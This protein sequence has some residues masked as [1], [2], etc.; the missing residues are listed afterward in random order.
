MKAKTERVFNL[1][2]DRRISTGPAVSSFVVYALDVGHL[3]LAPSSIP[4]YEKTALFRDK[5]QATLK[6]GQYL[7]ELPQRVY[8][9]YR[10]DEADYTVM[11]SEQKPHTVEIMV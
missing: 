2:F 6:N 11:A 10:L 4:E 7:V 5:A 1:K 3:A 8:E 9:F